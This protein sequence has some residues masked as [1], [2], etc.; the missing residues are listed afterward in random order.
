MK[1]LEAAA[2]ALEPIQRKYFEVEERLNE[3]NI[4]SLRPGPAVAI[5]D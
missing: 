5:G 4:V 2:A 3:A 1:D